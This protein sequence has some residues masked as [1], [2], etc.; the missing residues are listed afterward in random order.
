[1]SEGKE[2]PSL[3]M[4]LRTGIA[5]FCFQCPFS[6]Q[7]KEMI[8]SKQAFPYLEGRGLGQGLPPL[9]FILLLSSISK[10]LHGA[11]CHHFTPLPSHALGPFTPLSLQQPSGF[12]LPDKGEQA[13]S[14]LGSDC[15][16]AAARPG[17]CAPLIPSHPLGH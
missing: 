13:Q 10:P 17:I 11:F 4:T 12:G 1:M 6:Y 2:F 7:S 15:T 5:S 16:L 3:Q 9:Q 14:Y 8:C